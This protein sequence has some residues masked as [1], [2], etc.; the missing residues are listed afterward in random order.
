MN[1]IQPPAYR[2]NAQVGQVFVTNRTVHDAASLTKSG[3]FSVHHLMASSTV[4][5]AGRAYLRSNA[6]SC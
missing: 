6:R 2:T 4:R 3:H 1:M 5:V